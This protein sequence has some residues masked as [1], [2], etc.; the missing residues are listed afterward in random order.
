ML[1]RQQTEEWLKDR[2]AKPRTAFMS[3]RSADK[4]DF[5]RKCPDA[6][7]PTSSKY[8]EGG[9]AR[10]ARRP[11]MLKADGLEEIWMPPNVLIR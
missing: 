10:P 6:S 4:L 8:S 2:M 7:L 3:R 1:N 11:V 9:C 5:D